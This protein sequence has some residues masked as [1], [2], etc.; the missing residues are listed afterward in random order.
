MQAIKDYESNKWKVIGQKLGKPAKVRD[1]SIY[2]LPSLLRLR[3]CVVRCPFP[4]ASRV[5]A[6][7][8]TTDALGPRSAPESCSVSLSPNRSRGVASVPL[9]Q[10]EFEPKSPNAYTVAGIPTTRLGLHCRPRGVST[11][12]RPRR[13]LYQFPLEIGRSLSVNRRLSL[14]KWVVASGTSC[15]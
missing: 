6:R 13:T 11:L 14:S 4:D 7:L 9:R 15:G 5:T 8:S 10:A 1:F 12:S 2:V 3:S